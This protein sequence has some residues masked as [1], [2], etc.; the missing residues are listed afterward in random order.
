MDAGPRSA[1]LTPPHTG[2]DTGSFTLLRTRAPAT[3]CSA[4]RPAEPSSLLGRTGRV[5]VWAT[6][7]GHVCSVVISLLAVVGVA[8]VRWPLHPDTWP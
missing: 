6:S 1:S 5:V 8:G 7:S 3:T 2:K 4:S